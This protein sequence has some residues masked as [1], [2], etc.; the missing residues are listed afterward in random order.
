[1]VGV[2]RGLCRQGTN[3]SLYTVSLQRI[4]RAPLLP[5]SGGFA[6]NKSTRAVNAA[7][8]T[9]VSDFLPY[10]NFFLFMCA[11]HIRGHEANFYEAE[12]RCHEAEIEAEAR[13]SEAEAEADAE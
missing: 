5:M 1:M 11:V 6:A 2:L 12:V 7:T 9:A 13:K 4:K 10:F 3:E 8:H